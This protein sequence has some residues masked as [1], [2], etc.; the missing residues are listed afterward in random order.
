MGKQKQSENSTAAPDSQKKVAME[1]SEYSPS[2]RI[3]TYVVVRN[4]L[5][6]SD[7]EYGDPNDPAAISERDF[8]DRVEKKDFGKPVEIVQYD[9]KKHRVW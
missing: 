8:W 9:P 7:R 5:R 6:V 2:G 3:I 4:G 1:N